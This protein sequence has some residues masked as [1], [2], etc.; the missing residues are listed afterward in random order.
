MV[1]FKMKHLH[2][3]K[4]LN[5]CI[6]ADKTNRTGKSCKV[7]EGNSQSEVN[8]RLLGMAYTTKFIGYITMSVHCSSA[9]YLINGCCWKHWNGSSVVII[10]MDAVVISNT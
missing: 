6:L 7:Q 8:T 2:F 3:P 4:K 1:V 10:L 9:H 5:C